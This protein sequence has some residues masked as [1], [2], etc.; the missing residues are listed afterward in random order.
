MISESSLAWR[1]RDTISYGLRGDRVPQV[2]RYGF[3]QQ[4]IRVD[5]KF[6]DES[7]N[8]AG[9]LVQIYSGF[10][11]KS[12]SIG[13]GSQL[14]LMVQC[15][16]AY[17]LIWQPDRRLAPGR[18]RFWEYILPLSALDLQTFAQLENPTMPLFSTPQP[19]ISTTATPSTQAASITSV[20]LLPANPARKGAQ[21][22]NASPS[23]LFVKLGGVATATDYSFQMGTGDYYEVP[24]G[25][26]GAIGGIW[27]AASGNVLITELT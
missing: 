13:F 14:T 20:E 5:A 27:Q 1:L 16:D 8:N 10:Q 6:V 22:W 19:I 24:F 7:L 2:V 12:K 3:I 4:L 26:T 17:S 11:S 9:S 21:F 15:P 25:Y 23:T 18:I